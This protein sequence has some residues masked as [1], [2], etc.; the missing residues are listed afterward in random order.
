MGIFINNQIH[1]QIWFNPID[2]IDALP[3]L[4]QVTLLKLNEDSTLNYSS[5][6]VVVDFIQPKK[7]SLNSLK[8]LSADYLKV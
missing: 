3:N 8:T 7:L 4:Q 5:T 6:L 1:F 2:Y